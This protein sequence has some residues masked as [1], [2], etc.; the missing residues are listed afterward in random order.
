[1]VAQLLDN[2]FIEV[3]RSM[4]SILTDLCGQIKYDL[5]EDLKASGMLR[6]IDPTMF[7]NTFRNVA[8]T[9]RD[10]MIS[11]QREQRVKALSALKDLE[12]II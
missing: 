2:F 10:T 11:V 12:K 3:I 4:G 5:T 7:D 9:F 6:K 1:M 8:I